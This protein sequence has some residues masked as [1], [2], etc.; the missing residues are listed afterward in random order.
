MELAIFCV[1]MLLL[2]RLAPGELMG[3]W[4]ILFGISRFFLDFLRGGNVHI[5]NDS[6]TVGQVLAVLMVL[7]GGMLWWKRD[8]VEESAHIA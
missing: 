3:T 4:L 5:L 6:L 8:T 7:A 1:L 2:R